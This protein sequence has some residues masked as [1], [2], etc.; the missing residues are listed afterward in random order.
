M[1]DFIRAHQLNLML[2]LCGACGIMAF[3]L[4]I[5]KFLTPRRKMILILMELIAFFLLW[6]DRMAYIYAG[7]PGPQGYIM[8]RLSNLLVFFLTPAVV[9]G[10]NLYLMDYMKN[11][12]GKTVLPKRLRTVEFIAAGGMTLAIIS[13][14]TD[15]Y[16]YFDESNTYH[17]GNGFL[18]A[19]IIPVICPL[20]QY[21][22]IRQYK[23]VFSKLIYFSLGLYIFIPIAC[24]IIQIFTY[25]ISIVNMALVAVSVSLYIF[26]YIDIN[27]TVEEAH[28]KEMENMQ[29]EQRRMQRLFDQTATAFVSAVEKKD[30]FTKGNA[31]KVAE[32]A[33]R[34]AQL[35][36]KDEEECDKIYYTALLH[37]V[38]MIGI[39]DSVIKND[40]GPGKA[41]YEIIKRKPA[42]GKEILS[43][44]TEYPYLSQGAYYSHERYNGSG[45]PEGLKGEEIPEIARI[46]AVADA[47]V[48]MTT[49]KRYRESK[50]DFVAREAFVKGAGVEFDP[51]FAN[52]MV[53]IIDTD[54]REKAQNDISEVEDKISCGE[55]RDNVTTGI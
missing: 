29:G 22:V 27:H 13:A 2:L 53:R 35:C 54:R 34:I 41:D 38:G 32:Y 50:P 37:D 48:T 5:T 21:T 3:M 16:Y 49:K 42:I 43:S 7:V 23:K 26:T 36:G 28:K 31:V 30:D 40:R 51:V 12:G 45:Y 39:P 33:K 47:Y 11:E 6:F 55:Y 1:I 44:I 46:V 15:L 9:F 18:I 8:V 14:F 17:R 19:Y 10:F 4:F 20:I 24:G 52:A 25:G